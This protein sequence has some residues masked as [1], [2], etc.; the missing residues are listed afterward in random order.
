MKRGRYKAGPMT[1]AAMRELIEFEARC[2]GLEP[3]ALSER[4]RKLAEALASAERRVDANANSIRAPE[5]VERKPLK[6]AR[7]RP[8]MLPDDAQMY[9]AR[10]HKFSK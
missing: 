9:R 1:P 10:R 3:P 5:S 8:K 6:Q 7:R 4:D 2:K